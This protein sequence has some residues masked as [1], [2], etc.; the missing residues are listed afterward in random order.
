M[1]NRVWLAYRN[2]PAPVAVVYV[3]NW[4]VIATLR[5]PRRSATSSTGSLRAGEPALE[6]NA[7]RSAG[8]PSPDSP[9]SADRRSSEAG[10]VPTMTGAAE[11]SDAPLAA[12]ERAALIAATSGGSRRCATAPSTASASW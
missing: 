9:G 6:V 10:N 5:Q 11:G 3:A 4:F 2:L 7:S 8:A 1:R 12:D